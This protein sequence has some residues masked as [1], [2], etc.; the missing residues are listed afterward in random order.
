MHAAIYAYQH[1]LRNNILH[2]TPRERESER[3]RG[4]KEN[5]PS[6]GIV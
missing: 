6:I 2:M 3:E 4:T 1:L 5:T